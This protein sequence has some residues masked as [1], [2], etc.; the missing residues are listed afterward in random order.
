MKPFNCLKTLI[1]VAVIAAAG[2]F[3]QAQDASAP[4][5]LPADIAPGTPLAEVVK[6]VQAGVAADIIQNYVANSSSAFNLDADKIIFLKDEGLSSALINAMLARDKVLYAGSLAPAPAQAPTSAVV[7][8]PDTAPPPTEVTVNYFNDTL[9]PYGSWVEVEGYGR[10]WRPTAVIY[11]AGWRPYCD[12]GHWVYTDHGWYWDSDY[13]WGVTFHYG[14][15]FRHD[16]FGWCWY[17]D[18]VWAPSW[19][20]WRS[21]GEYCGWAPLPPLA[22]YRPGVGFFYRGGRVAVDFDFGLDAN[23][24]VFVASEHFGDRHPRS[25]SAPPERVTQIFNQTTVINNYN[26]NNNGNNHTIINHGIPVEHI[27]GA[28]HRP[29]EPVHV[30][31]LPNAGRQGWHGAVENPVR[32]NPVRTVGNDSGQ[33]RHGPAFPNN[34]SHNESATPRQNP[35]L[36]TPAHQP[37]NQPNQPNQPVRSPILNHPQPGTPVNQVS[38][39]NQSAKVPAFYHPQ[40][41][42]NEH[43]QPARVLPT[44]PNEWR[45]NRNA[46]NPTT[47]TPQQHGAIQLKPAMPPNNNYNQQP[48]YSAPNP[49]TPEPS[50]NVGND[51]KSGRDKPNH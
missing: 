47:T 14:R 36:P 40:P 30:A 6:M 16:R 31:S 15:W 10:C 20:T 41:A 7:S 2:Q 39:P 38:Q 48:A 33:F 22:V 24:F 3:G 37:D 18:T 45:Q 12:R 8:A 29:I 51:Q 35:V 17:P 34:P 1:A 42:V 5:T 26:V 19:V 9:T 23:R 27:S 28:T 11:D 46:E 50:H 25:Y 32:T 13:S 4:D 44:A 21:G 43:A 49:T